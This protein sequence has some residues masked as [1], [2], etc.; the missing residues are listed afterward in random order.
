MLLNLFHFDEHKNKVLFGPIDASKVHV[1]LGSSSKSATNLHLRLD[2]DF[3]LDAQIKS[4]VKSHR[5]LIKVKWRSVNIEFFI[6]WSSGVGGI[7]M[8]L[9]YCSEMKMYYCICQVHLQKLK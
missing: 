6:V 7:S 2:N 8:T 5:Q 9:K 3:K 1:D 4:E